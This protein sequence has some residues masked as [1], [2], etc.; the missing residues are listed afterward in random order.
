[1]PRGEHPSGGWLGVAEAYRAAHELGNAATA[2]YARAQLAKRRA[3]RSPPEVLAEMLGDIAHDAAR[4]ARLSIKV[5]RRATE[6]AVHSTR[7]DLRGVLR[8]CARRAVAGGRNV[9]IEVPDRP[10]WV[11]VDRDE[12][13]QV[14]DNLIQNALK[15]SASDTDVRVTCLFSQDRR[16]T[17][18]R[19]QDRGIG[20]P[21]P[22]QDR[23]FDPFYRSSDARERA[24]GEGLGLAI[25]R[26]LTEANGGRVELEASSPAGSTFTVRIPI[27]LDGG[28]ARRGPDRHAGAA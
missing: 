8:G 5:V 1:M 16:E 15:Y 9:A 4:L 23:I 20:I 22:E 13:E 18:V 7:C 24:A 17:V 3:L 19:V 10:V 12:L 21:T 25:A 6:L 14:L 28:R 27:A 2:L 26:E 11:R